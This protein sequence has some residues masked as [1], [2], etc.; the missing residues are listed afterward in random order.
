MVKQPLPEETSSGY[1]SPSSLFFPH[2]SHP[3]L[4]PDARARECAQA[5]CARLKGWWQFLGSYETY[6]PRSNPGKHG[7]CVHKTSSTEK[8]L[9][10]FCFSR[11]APFSSAH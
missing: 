11:H 6:N 2:T 4:T 1:L 5:M 3:F 7:A 8:T 10:S 9:G